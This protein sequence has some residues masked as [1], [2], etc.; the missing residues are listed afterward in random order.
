MKQTINKIRSVHPKFRTQA[1]KAAHLGITR[2]YY[3]QIVCGKC[4]PNKALKDLIDLIEAGYT[5]PKRGQRR[6]RPKLL[7]ISNAINTPE[8]LINEEVVQYLP[9]DISYIYF[10]VTG[11]KI[12][13][14]GVTWVLESR[15]ITHLT[16]KK[17]DYVFYKKVNHQDSYALETA[18]I[19][20][21]KPYYNLPFSERGRL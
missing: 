13:Y 17:F 19:E 16:D 2:Q 18:Y 20:R 3:N 12:V 8:I 6:E 1:E 9:E 15:I 10:L 11:K 21:F 4:I 7:K 5:P 14:I